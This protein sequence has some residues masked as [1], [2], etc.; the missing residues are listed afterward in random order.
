MPTLY[1]K[2][3]EGI[4]IGKTAVSILFIC[5]SVLAIC[6]CGFFRG[7]GERE[8]GVIRLSREELAGYTVIRPADADE[9]VSGSAVKLRRA[10]ED[11]CGSRVSIADDYLSDGEE[12]AANEILVG[13]TDRQESREAFERLSEKEGGGYSLS[14][15]S[16]SS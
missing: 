7:S 12:P 2:R 11:F 5:L 1:K 15:A 6:A 4:F 9:K 3:S 14:T 13:L 16:R 10:L 8:D